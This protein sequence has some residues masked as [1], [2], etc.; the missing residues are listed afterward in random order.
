M[1]YA[2]LQKMFDPLWEAGAANYFTSAFIDRLPDDAVETLAGFHSRSG[3]LPVQAE[4]HIHQLGGAV[5]RVRAD[6]TA[7]TD[8]T[9]PFIVN[10]VARTPEPAGLSP[11]R[12]WARAARD[13]MAAYGAGRMYI[14][15]TGEGDDDK[16]TAAYPPDLYARLR[17]VKDRYDPHNLFRF[18]QNVTPSPTARS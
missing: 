5:G 13:A 10:C 15:F 7:F 11:H 6:A 14:N 3:D 16:V 2:D 1:P 8:R 9:S 18:N 17:R 4:L 12:D